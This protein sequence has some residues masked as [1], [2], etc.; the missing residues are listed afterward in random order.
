MTTIHRL[1]TW[2]EAFAEVH[3]GAKTFEWRRDDRPFAE[4]DVVVLNEWE[5]THER[6]TGRRIV[7]DVGFVLRAPAFGVP[8]GFCVFSL[9]D[10]GDTETCDPSEVEPNAGQERGD[11]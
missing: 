10:V 7:A 1:K 2:P 4:G 8:D 9:V 5:P 3:C 6:Y 11:E